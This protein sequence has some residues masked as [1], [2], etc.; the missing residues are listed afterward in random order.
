VQYDDLKNSVGT[1]MSARGIPYAEGKDLKFSGRIFV[2]TMQP[3]TPI[4]I[5]DLM[6]WYQDAGMSLQIR[7]TDYWEANKD[8]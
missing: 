3:F 4:Q 7:G 6:K 8:R 1:G 5:G 2:Y